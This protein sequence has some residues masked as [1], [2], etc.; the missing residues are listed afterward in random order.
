MIPA[1]NDNLWGAFDK[2]G[3][4][5]LEFEYDSFGYIA[6]TDKDA[7]N[8]LLIP[9]YNVMVVAKDKKYALV[10]SVGERLCIFVLDDVYMTISGGTKYYT[11]NYNNTS[12]D[13]LEFLDKQG[14]KPGKKSNKED[15]KENSKDK[16]KESLKEN[17]TEENNI[18]EESEIEE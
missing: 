16:L 13:V 12:G 15:E 14:V 4:T 7:I 10:N 1:R 11:M 3:N 5:I 8:L 9:D 18:S 17:E 2:N 6:T